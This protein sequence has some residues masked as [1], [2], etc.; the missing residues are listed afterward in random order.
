MTGVSSE[1]QR[2][3]P[4]IGLGIVALCLALLSVLLLSGAA[5]GL[6]GV[7]LPVTGAE[8]RIDPFTFT[9]LALCSAFGFL[10]TSILL[11]AVFPAP[12]PLVLRAGDLATGAVGL[13]MVLV[14]S[15]GGSYVG[16]LTG[17]SYLGAPDLESG[18]IWVT[19]TVLAAILIAPALEELFFREILLTRVLGNLPRGLAI[20]VS[21]LA[22]GLFHL[23]SGGLILVASLTAMG[24]VMGWLRVRTASL[25]LPFLIHAMNNL[26]ALVVLS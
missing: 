17:E 7:D 8:V 11:L 23:A 14:F 3:Y 4:G 16:S 10:G 26:I 18:G 15:I 5:L 9:I 20:A 1:D 24:A 19:G 13:F 12:V 2:N 25:A 21:S 6:S 22:F